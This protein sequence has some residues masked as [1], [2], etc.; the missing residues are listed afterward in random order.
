[1]PTKNRKEE[2]TFKR[3]AAIEPVIG[4]L[5]SDHRAGK[6]LPQRANGRQY[7]LYD[8]SGRVQLQKVDGKTKANGSLAIFRTSRI[9]SIQNHPGIKWNLVNQIGNNNTLFLRLD[10]LGFDSWKPSKVF[11]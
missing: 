2:N 5:K 4:H 1:M 9:C 3:R 8:G 10:Y 7:Q 11:L 6:E